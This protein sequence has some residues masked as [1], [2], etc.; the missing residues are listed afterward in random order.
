MFCCAV[1]SARTDLTRNNFTGITSAMKQYKIQY[2]YITACTQR[3]RLSCLHK[4]N[5]FLHRSQL[6]PLPT[7]YDILIQLKAR[8]TLGRDMHSSQR[9]VLQPQRSK[10]LLLSFL[11]FC[12]ERFNCLR[13]LSPQHCRGEPGVSLRDSKTIILRLKLLQR[14]VKIHRHAAKILTGIQMS[15]AFDCRPIAPIFS[16]LV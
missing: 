8:Q 4:F 6:G 5:V 11:L 3:M 15:F 1:P 13:S 14:N 16:P 10:D 2:N 12:N 9:V 7:T